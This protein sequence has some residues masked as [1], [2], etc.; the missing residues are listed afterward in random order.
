MI[1]K[2]HIYQKK[3]TITFAA[4]TAVYTDGND[5]QVTFKNCAFFSDWINEFNKT[6]VADI[7]G[8]D[9]VM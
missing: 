1:T 7:K 6:Q 8:I 4:H 3:E 5:K 9:V 2:M